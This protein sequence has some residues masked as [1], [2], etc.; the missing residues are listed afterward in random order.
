MCNGN[1]SVNCIKYWPIC[2]H[3]LLFCNECI[4]LKIK[5]EII[6]KQ[7]PKCLHN[8]NCKQILWFDDIQKFYKSVT[9]KQQIAMISIYYSYH[10]QK[11]IICNDLY[12]KNDSV[13]YDHLHNCKNSVHSICNKCIKHNIINNDIDKI[14]SANCPIKNCK[15]ILPINYLKLI[16]YSKQYLSENSQ[17]FYNKLIKIRYVFMSILI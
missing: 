3:K 8:N 4:T 7:I 16:K 10:I 13:I 2:G 15:Q 1:F 6:R 12:Q 9:S 5:N 17:F 14:L 11:C